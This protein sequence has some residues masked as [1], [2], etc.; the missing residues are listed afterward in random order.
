MPGVALCWAMRR[1]G[2]I[3]LMI[4][5]DD[6]NIRFLFE[7]AAQRAEIFEPVAIAVDGQAAF[8]ALQAAA[9]ATLPALIVSD[10]CMPRMTGLELLRAVKNDTVLR[11]IPVAIIT[12]SDNPNDRELALAAGACSFVPKPYGVDALTKALIALWECC[13][14]A[15]GASNPT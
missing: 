14:K 9:S 6:V 15:A 3:S 1:S 10:L 13:D 11:T 12:S 5:E 7:A 4:V 8:D 2:K